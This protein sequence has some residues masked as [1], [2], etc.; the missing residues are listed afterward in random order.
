MNIISICVYPFVAKHIVKAML[1][2]D[3]NSFVEL[4][5]NGKKDAYE[6]IV[7]AIT[8]LMIWT[9]LILFLDRFCNAARPKPL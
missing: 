5:E 4:M 6:F 1:Q 3:E 9:P 8:L 2:M 7:N